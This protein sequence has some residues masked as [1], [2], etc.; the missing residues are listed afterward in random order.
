M[1]T[2]LSNHLLTS[3]VEMFE[4]VDYVGVSAIPTNDPLK[5]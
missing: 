1:H 3:P 4:E 2:N 5:R